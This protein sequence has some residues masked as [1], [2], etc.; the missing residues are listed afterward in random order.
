MRLFAILIGLMMGA[1]LALTCPSTLGR[2]IE[3]APVEDQIAD[4]RAAQRAA[5]IIRVPLPITLAGSQQIQ[6]S[7]QKFLTQAPSSIDRAVATD[8]KMKRIETVAY[9][10]P[11]DRQS[12][13][14]VRGMLQGHAVLVAIATNKIAMA[15]KTTIGSA[16]SGDDMDADV[17]EPA[18]RSIAQQRLA[19]LVCIALELLTVSNGS[20]R[21]NAVALKTSESPSIVTPSHRPGSW[22]I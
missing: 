6:Q 1:T 22:L 15:R 13:D 11:T 3:D 16:L 7:L 5:I 21:K 9:I 14:T 17:I 12:D 19:R 20:T 10:R 8:D 2:T 18:Y 4:S